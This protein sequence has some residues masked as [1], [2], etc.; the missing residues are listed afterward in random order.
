MRKIL[1]FLAL[2]ASVLHLS[3]QPAE[4]GTGDIEQSIASSYASIVRYLQNAMKF[5][6]AVPQEKVY[7]HFDN[8]GYFANETMWFKAYVV[9]TDKSAPTDISRVLY[10]ELLNPSG[11]VIKTQKLYIDDK[12]QAHGDIKLDTLFGSGFYEVRAYTRYM[13]NW[14]TNAVFSRVFPIF[15]TP[16]EEGAY[17]SPVIEP[18]TYRRRDPNNRQ[19]QDEA[20]TNAVKEGVHGASSA[21]KVNVSFYP[22]GGDMVKGKKSRV[23]LLAVRDNGMPFEGKGKVATADGTVVADVATDSLGR[24][25]FYVTPDGGKMVLDMDND[26]K[27]HSFDL[28]SARDEGCT[29][30]LDAV[31]D[32]M[33]LTVQCSPKLCGR[34]MGYFIMNNGNI[35]FC[36]TLCAEPK[37]EIE[38]D[39]S[40]MREGVNQLTFIS[41][42]GQILA[43]RLFFIT[44]KPSLE[45]SIFF[46]TSLTNL[47][48]CC[49]IGVDVKARPNT[50][51]SFSAIDM[52]TMNNGK[53]GNMKTW[54]LLSSDVRGY[55][56]NVDYYFEADDKEHRQ[57]ADMLMLTQ[58]WRRYDW[59]IMAGL[60][61][62]DNPQPIEDKFYIF[63]QLG[64]YRKRNPVANV[65]MEVFLYN[66]N[67]ESLNGK[68]VT[69]SLGNYAFELPFV[70]GEWNMQIFTRL[71]D[72]R[73]TYRVRI[74]RQFSPAP[75]YV[76]P[77]ESSAYP[78]DSIRLA[79]SVANKKGEEEEEPFVPITKKNILLENVTIKAKKRYFTNDNWQY[80]NESYGSKYASLFYDIDK[81]LDRIYDLGEEQPTLFEFLCKKN[82]LFDNPEMRD[83][84]SPPRNID[85]DCMW[86]GSMSYAGQPIKWI[87]DNG[88]RQVILP[89][90]SATLF[91]AKRILGAEV[92]T[93][94]LDT[95]EMY[96][97]VSSKVGATGDD[98][99]PIWME[100]Y[101]SLYIVPLSPKERQACV[102]IYLYSH[103]KLSTASNKGLR[104][105]YFEGFNT[106]STFEME[107]YSVI[108]PMADFRR[109]IYWAPDVTT[110]AQGKAH[111]S[112]FNN[113]TTDAIYFSAEGMDTDGRIAV[114]K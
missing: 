4:K 60:S 11:D 96:G 6:V 38:L 81:E 32:D 41:N 56:H 21:G 25:W 71:D 87:V 15:E 77:L 100:D 17:D 73:K 112:F 75:R 47:K 9:R 106:P 30:A 18:K 23:A 63:G 98:M 55:I 59:N 67:G 13:T 29:I 1:L 113:S 88:Q 37:I 69:D 80:K 40:K 90:D 42:R 65:E 109:T 99:F 94:D 3:A 33:L 68:T 58:G 39:R 44:P 101:K 16:S 92:D 28:P 12:G 104:H 84:P 70:D 61:T 51:F 91:A 103:I 85:S 93:T 22:E 114:S 31:S 89:L 8:T 105:T 49:K 57:A 76:T 107:D 48:P 64:E 78:C 52:K 19:A 108:P 54:M 35:T 102:R 5:N 74:D 43:E 45:D 111:I 50:T 95:D 62:F 10:V 66:Q 14:G 27:T 86:Q 53:Q 34:L 2:L 110:D 97:M 72:K 20:Y 46:S 36:D 79:P 82:A 7:L 26:G 24:G 83:L